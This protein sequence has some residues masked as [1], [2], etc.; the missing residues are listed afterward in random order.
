MGDFLLDISEQLEKIDENGIIKQIINR[1]VL[2]AI[3]PFKTIILII[4]LLFTVLIITQLL[5]LWNIFKI[6]TRISL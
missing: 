1:F 4:I 5:I 2:N 3:K 6:S